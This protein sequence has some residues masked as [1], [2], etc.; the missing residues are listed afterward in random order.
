MFEEHP[1]SNCSISYLLSV[2]CSSLSQ[3]SLQLYILIHQLSSAVALCV[4]ERVDCLITP[5]TTF[6][7][8]VK[9]NCVSEEVVHKCQCRPGPLYLLCGEGNVKSD[10][11]N[12]ECLSIRIIVCVISFV[13]FYTSKYTYT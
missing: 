3:T 7:L 5:F 6:G 10:T 9:Q 11:E 4:T 8:Y 12:E 2:S 1:V 13:Y